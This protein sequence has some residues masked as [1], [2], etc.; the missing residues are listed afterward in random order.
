MPDHLDSVKGYA[1]LMEKWK[2][3]AEAKGEDK[4]AAGFGIRLEG[5]RAVI[6]E[7][8]HLRR[9]TKPIP[10]SYGDLSDLPAEL[11]KELTGIKVDDLEQQIFTIIKSGGDEVDL[12][13]VLIELFRRFQVV[14]SRK[15][16]QNKLW[17]MAQKEIIYSV[18]GRKGI[19]TATK[20]AEDDDDFSKLI[21]TAPK[22]SGPPFDDDLDDDV[23]F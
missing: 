15:F 19:Y 22:P 1:R 7:L 20:P 12:D 10:A 11:I 21:G 17:R 23:P 5:F 4:T 6:D 14:Q 8:E 2:S 9:I 3:E 13:A 16:L 18:P